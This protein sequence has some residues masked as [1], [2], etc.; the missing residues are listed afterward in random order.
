MRE[1]PEG[2]RTMLKGAQRAKS[3]VIRGKVMG[4]VT[5]DLT[6]SNGSQASHNSLNVPNN[7]RRYKI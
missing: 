5:T 7:S 3:T 4:H 2:R 6:I 1:L